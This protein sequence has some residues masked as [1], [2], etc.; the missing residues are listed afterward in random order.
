MN[1]NY[2]IDESDIRRISNELSNMQSPAMGRATILCSECIFKNV[3]CFP[4]RGHDG[5][6]SGW[7]MN[8]KIEVIA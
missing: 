4:S 8:P 6:L 2:E 1:S 3:T 5:C 7:T